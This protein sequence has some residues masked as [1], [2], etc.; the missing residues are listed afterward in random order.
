MCRKQVILEIIQTDYLAVIADKSTDISSQT[1]FVIVF[2]YINKS[3]GEEVERFWSYF[4]PESVNTEG[5]S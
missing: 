4:S 5:I 1:Q 2:R 3:S